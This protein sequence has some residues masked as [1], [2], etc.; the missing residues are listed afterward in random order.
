MDLLEDIFLPYGQV[1]WD[2][3]IN[4]WWAELDSLV[5]D[6]WLAL[7][8]GFMHQNEEHLPLAFL[9]GAIASQQPMN[10]DGVA[11]YEP[12]FFRAPLSRLL[13]LL[14]LP[15]LGRWGSAVIA[16]TGSRRLSS[17]ACNALPAFAGGIHLLAHVP[18]LYIRVANPQHHLLRTLL[19]LLCVLSTC[20]FCRTSC[21]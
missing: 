18:C 2:D 14:V 15:R 1:P 16:A 3:L 12:D 8:S 7:D 10:G 17:S 11:P 9:P 21:R 20:S 4:P 6:A 5:E 13:T 19:S